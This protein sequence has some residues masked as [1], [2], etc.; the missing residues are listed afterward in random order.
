[1]IVIQKT[2][3]MTLPGQVASFLNRV[4]LAWWVEVTTQ[5]PKCTYYFG[6]FSGIKEAE[7]EVA[8]YVEDLQKEG[9]QNIQTSIRR[10]QPK[11]LT[12]F[13]EFDLSPAPVSR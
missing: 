13:D 3:D 8:G 6:P 7:A 1:L 11:E 10:C 12:V 4:G 5:E 2:G 9:A